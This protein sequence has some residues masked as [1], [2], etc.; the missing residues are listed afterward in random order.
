[1]EREGIAKPTLTG[2]EYTEITAYLYFLRF[3][4]KAGDAAQGNTSSPRRAAAPAILPRA[5]GKDGEPGLDEFPRNASPV[6]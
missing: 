2:Q 4:D 5:R 6:S 1:M 3:F